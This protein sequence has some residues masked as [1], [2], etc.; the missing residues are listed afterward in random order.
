MQ[1]SAEA[2]VSA[3]VEHNLYPGLNPMVPSLLINARR[4]VV[5]LFDPETDFL[6]ISQEVFRRTDDAIIPSAHQV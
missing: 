3:F 6:L 5:T 2:V 4:F 1:F